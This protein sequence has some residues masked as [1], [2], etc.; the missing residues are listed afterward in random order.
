MRCKNCDTEFEGKFCPECGTAAQTDRAVP[1]TAASAPQQAEPKKPIYKKWWFWLIIVVIVVSLINQ[2]TKKDDADDT[3]EDTSDISSVTANGDDKANDKADDKAQIAVIDLSAMDR[4]AIQSWADENH[5]IVSF[6][7][8]YSDSVAAGAFLSQSVNVSDSIAEGD[9]IEVVYSLGKKPSAEYINALHKAETYSSMMKMSKQGIY[10][11]LV[12]EYGEKF[13]AD[14]AQYAVDTIQ[15]DWNANALAKAK[16]YR[17][18][19]SM[20]NSAIYDQL[21]SE[22][23]E[24]FTAEQAQYAVDHLD[25]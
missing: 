13:P 14:A 15:A 1:L 21:I 20:S 23:G 19:M 17:D 25:G 3:S 4:E 2:P 12:S 22:Y 10:D 16:T 6:G 18:S 9:T 5:V 7:D 8:A 11:Q 24:Q